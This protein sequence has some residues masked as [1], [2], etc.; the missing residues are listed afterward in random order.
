MGLFT[1]FGIDWKLLVAQAVNFLILLAILYKWLYRPLVR[2]LEQRRE[3]IEQS[4][5]EAKRIERELQELGVTKEWTLHEARREAEEIRRRAE[6]QAET[7]RQETLGKV[8]AEAERVVAEARHKFL[9]ER[10]ELMRQVRQQAASLVAQASAKVLGRVMMPTLDKKL[11]DEAV[12]E[13]V[14]RQ[15]HQQ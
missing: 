15:A 10:E 7:Q 5:A 9:A 4:L 2:F 11:I 12:R 1:T 13:V 14:N 3:R 6:A 8:R